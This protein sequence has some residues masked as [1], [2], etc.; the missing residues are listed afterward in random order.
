MK[1]GIIGCAGRMGRMLIETVLQT[2]GA[3]LA[4]GCEAPGSPHQ[5]KDLAG[6]VGAPPSGLLVSADARALFVA[7][8]VVIDFTTPSVTLANAAIAAEAGTALVVGT[9]GFDSGQMATLRAK[10][11]NTVIIQASNFSIGVN[12]LEGLTCQVAALLGEEY[13]IEIVEMHHKHKVDVP[14]GTALALGEAAATGRRVVLDNVAQRGRDGHT[15]A[16]RAGDIGFATLRGGD[17]VGDHTVI[18]AGASERV[19]LTHKAASRSVFAC[20]AVRSALW[21]VGRAPGFYT[22]RDVLGFD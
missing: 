15:G 18:F 3:E 11:E 17:V 22:M 9:T 2:D 4:G 7:A 16:R 13:D 12:L 21:S 1:I 10:A 5:G 14:S 6:L 20:G 19:E 8:G